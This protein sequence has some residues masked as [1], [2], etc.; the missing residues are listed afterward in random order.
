MSRLTVTEKEHWKSRIEKRINKAIE[1]LES[2]N[3]EHFASIRTKAM[4]AA[5]KELN[6]EK[7]AANRDRLKEERKLLESELED[8][9]AAIEI[10]ILGEVERKKLGTYYSRNATEQK[11]KRSTE[12]VEER[13]LADGGPGSELL[14]LRE[15]RES[16]LDTVWLATSSKQIRDL[17]CRVGEVL[18]EAPTKIQEQLLSVDSDCE[19]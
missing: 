17:W 10:A 11:I 2:S 4:D 13:L 6:I 9:E 7:L 18:G 16:L 5:L 3:A 1:V 19:R 15:E 14:R 8:A 12:I